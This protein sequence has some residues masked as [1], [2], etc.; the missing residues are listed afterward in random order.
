MSLWLDKLLI[1][2]QIHANKCKHASNARTHTHVHTHTHTHTHIHAHNAR[3]F[4]RIYPMLHIYAQ[5]YSALV[6]THTHTHTHTQ[7]H[8]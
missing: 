4:T 1:A 8:I 2:T 7:M 5:T 6:H 3:T